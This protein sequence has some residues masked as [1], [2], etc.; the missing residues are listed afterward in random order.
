MTTTQTRN[1][2]A[3]VAT[4]IVL[5]LLIVTPLGA[6]LVHDVLEPARIGCYAGFQWL[7]VD[8]IGSAL[9]TIAG[10]LGELGELVS[11]IF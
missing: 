11:S 10:L 7:F 1:A 9:Y 6:H 2:A 3:A 4:L 5:G 8:T